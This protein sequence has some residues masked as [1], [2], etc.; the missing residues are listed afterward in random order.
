MI[1]VVYRNTLIID[2]EYTC[3]VTH[4]N[5]S[6]RTTILDRYSTAILIS[7]IPRSSA[8]S[9]TFPMKS[10]DETLEQIVSFTRQIHG[11]VKLGL[12]K[13]AGVRLIHMTG[14]FT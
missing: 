10:A 12:Y 6:V 7:C 5:G 4:T 9:Y 8:A 3:V 13:P 2:A 1:R 11:T 14:S